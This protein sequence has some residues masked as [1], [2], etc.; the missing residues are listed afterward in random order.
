[1]K[2]FSVEVEK[3]KKLLKVELDL[4]KEFNKQQ[5]KRMKKGLGKAD[6]DA[7]KNAEILRL[8]DQIHQNHTTMLE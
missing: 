4:L 5:V 6:Y 1:M 8:H 3:D 2:E 7:E